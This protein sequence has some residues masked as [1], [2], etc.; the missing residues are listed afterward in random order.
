MSVYQKL[1]MSVC[2]IHLRPN[3]PTTASVHFY[4]KNHNL[5]Q[6]SPIVVVVDIEVETPVVALSKELDLI[7]RYD[8]ENTKLTSSLFVP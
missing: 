3:L 8:D 1:N 2:C 7:E 6:S 4:S 5:L